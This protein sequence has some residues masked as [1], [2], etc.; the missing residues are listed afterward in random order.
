MNVKEAIITKDGQTDPGSVEHRVAAMGDD[1]A[2]YAED[3]AARNTPWDEAGFGRTFRHEVAHV[4]GEVRI[5]YVI[6]GEGEPLVLLHGFPEH[7]RE[8]RLRPHPLRF[9]IIDFF[10]RRICPRS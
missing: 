5:H 9:G 7:W 2:L 10:K 1:A 8:W 3:V 6:G 4:N